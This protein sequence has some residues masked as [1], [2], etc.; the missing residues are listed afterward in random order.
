MEAEY[1][2]N[3]L[4][5]HTLQCE[6][7]DS[8]LNGISNYF[9]VFEILPK[10]PKQFLHFRNNS[11]ELVRSKLT[12]VLELNA[13]SLDITSPPFRSTFSIIH[14]RINLTLYCRLLL[15]SFVIDFLA[16]T[17]NT[18]ERNPSFPS[19]RY[20]IANFFNADFYSFNWIEVSLL[21]YNYLIRF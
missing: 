1:K 17:R 21:L 4:V 15:R 8:K 12:S 18:S 14:E 7:P 2:M 9:L 13:V 3:V 6:D 5:A 19:I 10:T 11:L 20:C 16:L